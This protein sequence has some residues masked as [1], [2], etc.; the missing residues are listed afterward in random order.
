MKSQSQ[1]EVPKGE[2]IMQAG[3]EATGLTAG[4]SLEAESLLLEEM[5]HLS[6]STSQI[7]S[8]ISSTQNVY[9][10]VVGIIATAVAALQIFGNE[11][12][13]QGF[14]KTPFLLDIITIVALISGGVLSFIFLLRFLQLVK[15]EFHCTA[16]MNKIRTFYIDHLKPRMPLIEEAFYKQGDTEYFSN[17]PP[18]VRHI[19]S[20]LGSLSFGGAFYIIFNYIASSIFLLFSNLFLSVTVFIVAFF[21]QQWYSRRYL[22]KFDNAWKGE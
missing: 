10:I 11:L 18:Y 20:L 14:S 6:A 2:C 13:R 3:H 21:L 4:I 5:R 9:L 16:A 1:I 12:R 19:V 15:R 17:V 22:S 7:N 8:E